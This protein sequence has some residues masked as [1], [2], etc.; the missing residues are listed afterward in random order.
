M[1]SLIWKE[2][3]ENLKWVALPSLLIL[4]AMAILGIPSLMDEG[5]LF[6]ASIIS[7][8]FGAMLGF[9]Q[10]FSESR[11]DKRSLLLHRPLTST[12]IFLGKAL[13]GGGLYLVAVGIPFLCAVG[14]AATPGHVPEPFGWRMALPWL[15]DALAGLVCYFA[16]MLTAQREARWYGSRCLGLAACVFCWHL[17]WTLT[18]FWQALVAIAI[19]GSLV[20]VAAWGSFHSGGSYAAQ[21]RVARFALATTFLLGLLAISFLGKLF[22]GIFFWTRNGYYYELGRDGRVLS[23]QEENR[24]LSVTDLSGKALP[25]LEGTP[26]DY[27]TFKEVVAPSVHGA[28]PKTQSYR[29]SNRALIKYG[30]ATRPGNE[31]WWF[32]PDQGR[33]QGFDKGTKLSIGSYGP[34]GFAGPGVQATDRFQGELAHASLLYFSHAGPYLVFPGGVYAVNFRKRTVQ[35]VFVP[36]AGETVQWVSHWEEEARKQSADFV[37]TDNSV[38]VF[39]EVAAPLFTVALDHAATYE[40]RS[41]GRLENPER[42]WI[43]YRPAWYLGFEALDSMPSYVVVYDRSGTETGPRQEMPAR[44]G[45]AHEVSPRI[46]SVHPSGALAWFGPVTPPAEAVVLLTTTNYLRSKTRETEGV[47]IPLL[48]EFLLGTTQQ[49][50]PGIRWRPQAH[51]GLVF[52]FVSTTMLVSLVSGLICLLL[53]RRHAFSRTRAIGWGLCG[54][55]WGVAGLLL[56][57]AVQEWPAHTPC[58]KCRKLRVVTR[59]AC[60]HCGAAQA[61]PEADG[62][63]IYE[64]SSAAVLEVSG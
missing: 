36:F 62:T 50:L 8:L 13:V 48:F 58:P 22:L 45:F 26:V 54:V 31:E 3:R 55:V 37:I 32:V 6:Y 52:A 61:V 11:G 40:V 9:V 28:V 42:Y 33:L 25:Q 43:W 2:F 16:G 10:V 38:H 29:N 5:F 41:V 53:A 4:G 56:M 17:V 51:P 14:L 46:P 7:G 20:A 23:V 27:Y 44:S 47:E 35:T 19:V 24:V 15:A 39:D 63:E 30:N 60:E 59:D 34:A 18:E 64:T 21:P 49:F 12:Q 1:K 57:L